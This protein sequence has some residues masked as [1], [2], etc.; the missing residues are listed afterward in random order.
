MGR[1]RKGTTRVLDINRSAHSFLTRQGQ[2]QVILTAIVCICLHWN[3]WFGS[4]YSGSTWTKR[5]RLP[6]KS[7]FQGKGPPK[8]VPI[9][10]APYDME[11]QKFAL[12]DN[13][14]AAVDLARKFEMGTKKKLSVPF[15]CQ[16]DA[17]KASVWTI[18]EGHGCHGWRGH[19]TQLLHL[20][21]FVGC[22]ILGWG[23]DTLM[24]G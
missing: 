13:G 15:S 23:S 3:N 6:S 12:F 1:T 4:W 20:E 19:P 10:H 17:F 9:K 7:F 21:L 8:S 22:F 24:A 2:S 16:D 14:S 18:W 11:H 5:G